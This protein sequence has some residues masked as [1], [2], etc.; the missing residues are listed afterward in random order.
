MLPDDQKPIVVGITWVESCRVNASMVD[1]EPFLVD[2][3]AIDVPVFKKVC[4]RV[5]LLNICS[6][7]PAPAVDASEVQFNL[8]IEVHEQMFKPPDDPAAQQLTPPALSFGGL[9]SSG[10]SSPPFTPSS[11]HQDLRTWITFTDGNPQ[12]SARSARDS[13]S[14]P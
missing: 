4:P 8:Y 12:N 1:V 10:N 9:D 3:N 14:L 6:C 5:G 2:L 11:A 13:I 7:Y